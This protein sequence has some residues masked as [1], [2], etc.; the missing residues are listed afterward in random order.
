MFTWG[1]LVRP[2]SIGSFGCALGV[3]GFVRGRQG[4]LRYALGVSGVAG[5]IGVLLVFIQGLVVHWG[6]PGWSL[7]L[8]GNA[9]FIGVCGR[10]DHW[11]APWELLGSYGVNWFIGVRPVGRQGHPEVAGF[12]GVRHRGRRVHPG[13]LGLFTPCRSSGSS[14]VAGFIGMRSEVRRVH[15]GS[16]GSLGWALGV[17]GFS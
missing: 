3:V 4:S 11:G 12:I 7:G 9:V 17:V 16:L 14:R 15:P 2:G 8:S 6:A 13:S 5:F 1:R 10:W